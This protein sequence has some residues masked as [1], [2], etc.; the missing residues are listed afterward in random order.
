MIKNILE[1]YQ[2]GSTSLTDT[3]IAVLLSAE[4]KEREEVFEAARQ[5]RNTQ[6][7]KDVFLYGFIY[8][9]TYCRNNCNFCYYR[10]ANNEPPR[11]RKSFEEIAETA[12][13]MKESGINLIDLTMGEDP[14]YTENPEKLAEIVKLVKQK[15]NLPVMVSPGVVSDECIKLLA[16]AGADWY[17]LYQETHNPK[18][19][20]ELR[21]GQDYDMRMHCK[22]LARE[23]GMLIE[24]GVLTGV[25]ETRAD[26]IHSFR[27]MERIGAK[28]V[29]TMTFIPQDGIPM[30]QTGHLNFADELLNIAVMR[31]L[32]PDKLIPA[33]LD[34]DGLNGLESRLMAGAN[35]ITSIIPP[36]KGYAGVAHASHDID[37]GYRTVEGV[38]E[39]IAKCGLVQADA[40]TYQTLIDRWKNV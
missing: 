7:D 20:S 8:F 36:K 29:R 27:E 24:E 37:E 1:K 21:L 40:K 9:S 23:Y 19:F 34:V 3:E 31:L 16:S 10:N 14:Y 12:V 32:Y 25:G 15:T 33:S 28:Q 6:F 17:A 13:S 5:V 2:K 39:T 11:Y 35:V 18:L 26:R 4:G 38:Q 22:A 30:Q